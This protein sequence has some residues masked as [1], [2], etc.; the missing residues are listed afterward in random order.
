LKSI[1]LAFSILLAIV[2]FIYPVSADTWQVY[3]QSNGLSD[4]NV[5]CFA[6]M[7]AYMA[8]GT[9]MGADVY[10]GETSSWHKLKLPV[11]IAS[12][13]IKDIAFDKNG[14]IW[15]ASARGLAHAQGKSHHLYGV[16]DGLPTVDIDRIQ[17]SEGKIYA[18]CFGGYVSHANVPLTGKTSFSPVNYRRTDID[19]SFRMKSVGISGLGMV[20]PAKGWIS[21]RGEGLIEQLGPNSYPINGLDGMPE[22]WVND[23]WVFE[24]PSRAIHI[25]SITPEHISLIKNSNTIQ[26]FRLPMKD[27][28]L[29]CII[30]IK[31]NPDAFSAL[32]LPEMNEQE[33]DFFKFLDKRSLYVGTRN[34]GL[35]RYQK[36]VWT[37]FNST[38][39]N[40]PSNCINRLYYMG[41]TLVLCTSGGLVIIS[42]NSQQ[43]DEF[44]KQGIGNVYAK[45]LFP[46]PPRFAY[47]IPFKQICKGSSYWFSHLHGLSRWRP[48]SYPRMR[49]SDINNNL[50]SRLEIL[51]DS[52]DESL[53]FHDETNEAEE[54]PEPELD[55][56]ELFS[57]ALHGFWQLFSTRY[58]PTFNETSFNANDTEIIDYDLYEIY[59]DDITWMDIDKSTDML[60]IIFNGNRLC[61]MQ[62]KQV[63][64]E[65]GKKKF[66]VE[67]PEWLFMG[68]YQPWAG[69]QELNVVWF[70][71][72]KLYIGTKEDGF[73]ILKNPQ[74]ENLKDFPFEWEH[75]GIYEGLISS[76][77]IGFSRWKSILGDNLVIL[78]EKAISLWDGEFFRSLSTG[79]IREYTCLDASSDGNLWIGSWGGLFR[80]TPEANLRSY[81]A[82]NARFDSNYITAVA[83][84]PKSTHRVT[85]VWVACDELAAFTATNDLFNGSDQPPNVYTTADGKKI[86]KEV[87]VDGSSLHF[88]DG[89]TWEKFKMA[90]VKHMYI[91]GDYLWTTSN[92]RVRRL[93]AP[94]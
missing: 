81:T 61:R 74:S 69:G 89:R 5:T 94:R 15:V 36:G 43:Y 7:G 16:E 6:A 28:W 48:K 26:E 37:N 85:G 68:K 67:R 13:P 17:I 56:E 40:L 3:T 33:T 22:S 10:S 79:A 32:E 8:V 91:E 4:N 84:L 75:Y 27:L 80:F 55:L 20:S 25:I 42:L 49:D 23:F 9:N 47:M 31:E 51:N 83:A 88:F 24:G 41:Q 1:K 70:N 38:D 46:F 65:K 90:G 57:P 63:I 76:D 2:S 14:H 34:Q 52:S 18:G 82:S 12:S 86:V 53:N 58:W 59:S 35:W 60:W 77:C 93:L 71:D 45:T 50:S 11:E 44:K 87:V 66:K 21:T 92:I 72:N 54:L 29:N 78:H 39:S 30:A 64:E 19:K 62:M 73:Y